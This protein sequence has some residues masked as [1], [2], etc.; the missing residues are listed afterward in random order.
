ML[1]TTQDVILIAQDQ[2]GMH[3]TT[4]FQAPVDTAETIRLIQTMNN[5][6][7]MI[8]TYR[9]GM[10]VVTSVLWRLAGHVLYLTQK[11]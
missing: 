4:I 1:L 9:M 6:S 3:V 2:L 11:M 10:D 8:G 7:A 5:I